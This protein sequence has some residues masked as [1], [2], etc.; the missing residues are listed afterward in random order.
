MKNN[1]IDIL[2][3][4]FE[5]LLDDETRKLENRHL[6]EL[7]TLVNHETWG[8]KEDHLKANKELEKLKKGIV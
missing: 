5:L 1:K 6:K 2:I 8:S 4:A 7:D 3:Q